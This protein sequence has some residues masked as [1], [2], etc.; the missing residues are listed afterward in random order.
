MYTKEQILE[1]TKQGL[2]QNILTSKDLAN[3]IDTKNNTKDKFSKKLSNILYVIG[4]LII[5][6]GVILLTSM[7]W[8]Q[9]SILGKFLGTFGVGLIA[10]LAGIYLRGDHW[11]ILSSVA[12]TISAVVLPL[13]VYLILDE[14]NISIT[15]I[16]VAAVSSVM[17][18]VLMVAQILTK[19]N[20]I[21]FLN[22]CYASI[23]Y[24]AFLS[25]IGMTGFEEYRMASLI[26]AISFIFYN[27]FYISS[28][29]T[30]TDTDEKEIS[31]IQ[32]LIYLISSAGIF[33]LT[34]TF[35][36]I[37][38]LLMIPLLFGGFYSGIYVKSRALLINSAIFTMIYVVKISSE[39]F[40]GI[41]GW[42]VLL[43]VLGIV[44]VGIGLFTYKMSEKYIEE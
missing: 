6:A 5:L 27:Y 24:Y 23:A 39:Y 26:L 31:S 7:F 40:S 9:M 30:N 3:I 13:G 33:G 37:S 15:A 35:G 20:I 14:A 41:L 18:V 2:E 32:N 22:S 28:I 29:Q 12:L 8:G 43:I 16:I 36:Q 17:I 1:I 44:I 19:R 11:R 38:D 4:G 10:Y 34:L 42:P 21:I 25:A